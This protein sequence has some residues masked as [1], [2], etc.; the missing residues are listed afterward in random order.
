MVHSGERSTT[1]LF[2]FNAPCAF[3]DGEYADADQP[4]HREPE[5]GEQRLAA[6]AERDAEQAVLG[7]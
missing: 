7:R 2:G 1:G 3:G 5:K 4:E 6:I